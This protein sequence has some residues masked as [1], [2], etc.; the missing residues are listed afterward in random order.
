V[1]HIY[2]FSL[3]KH[4][5]ND[6]RPEENMWLLLENFWSKDR[7]DKWYNAIF[8]TGTEVC[9]NLMCLSASAH[10]YH[11]KSYFALKPISISQDNTEMTV[12]FYWLKK[13]NNL[14]RFVNLCE[15]PLLNGVDQGP[16]RARLF[17]HI[18]AEVIQ[19]GHQLKLKTSDP[20]TQPLPNYHLLE[21]QWFLN[22]LVA[23]AGAADDSNDYDDDDDDDNDEPI[24]WQEEED[25]EMLSDDDQ[26]SHTEARSSPPS[27]LSASSQKMAIRSRADISQSATEATTDT[28]IF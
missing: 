3:R 17:N 26:R 22:R 8:P 20:D 5:K 19:S 27:S 7:V 25:Y 9:S 18:T 13:D 14:P 1:A 23:M 6:G 21:M 12:E 2:P 16:L 4:D 15:K 10:R 28:V 24:F 11:G